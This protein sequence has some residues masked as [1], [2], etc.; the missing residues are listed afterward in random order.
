MEDPPPQNANILSRSLL[1]VIKPS[2][3][4]FHAL[5]A[6][7][8][9]MQALLRA[10]EYRREHGDFPEMLSDLPTDPFT[11]KPMQYRY[12][13]AEIHESVLQDSA[14]PWNIKIFEPGYE[15]RQAKVVQIWSIG[16]N[17]VDDGGVANNLL[18]KD[19][20]CATIRLD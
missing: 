7:V 8:L 18:A 11:G 5:T 6:R 3:N 19:D 15:V 2:G 9:A 14:L 12:G 1:L 17:G 16:P 10:E 20:A 4:K 13:T